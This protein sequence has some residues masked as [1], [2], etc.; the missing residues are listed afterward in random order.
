M[1]RSPLTSITLAFSLDRVQ[2]DQKN[3]AT[4]AF[5]AVASGQP[6]Q[7]LVVDGVRMTAE[8]VAFQ[9]ALDGYID[10]SS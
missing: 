8:E 9:V 1:T 2:D 10:T 3:A 6:G 5:S 7:L 4:K